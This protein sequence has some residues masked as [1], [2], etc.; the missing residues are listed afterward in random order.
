LA[1]VRAP[2]GRVPAGSFGPRARVDAARRGLS[3][4]VQAS[5]DFGGVGSWYVSSFGMSML[6]PLE[7]QRLPPGHWH[8]LPDARRSSSDEL[9]REIRAVTQQPIVAA[10]LDAADVILLVLNSRREI[11]AANRLADPI[12]RIAGTR[13]GE[14]L[15]CANARGG[16]GTAPACELCGALGAILGCERTGAPVEAECLVRTDG[17]GPLELNVRA[18]PLDVGGHRFTILSLRDVAAEKRRDALEQVFFH[19]VLNSVAGLRGWAQRLRS[20]TADHGRA[21]DRIDH[22]SRH[23]EREIRDH[24]ALMLAERGA[25]VPAAARVAVARV[26]EDLAAV[27]SSHACA[28]GRTLAISTPPPDEAL[29]TDAALLLRVLVNMTRNALEATPEG[30]TVEVAYVRTPGG[31]RFEVRNPGAMPPEV[32]AR[33]FQRSFSTKAS[34]GRGLGTY[35]MKLLGERYLRGA[36]T[37]TSDAAAGTAFRLELPLRL[38][39]PGS[40]HDG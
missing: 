20:P 10:L 23:V 9:A 17:G 29:E 25:L 37:F 24:R 34:R 33:I 3:A 15:T 1:E 18:T 2:P 22:L 5:E 38:P 6:R 27:L 12:T 7:T 13:P 8:P 30:G 4:C 36:V 16:C 14:A 28:E 35:G 26:L 39:R 31:A 40:V 32:Q 19:D 11:V 21:A